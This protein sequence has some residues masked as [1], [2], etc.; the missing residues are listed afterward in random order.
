MIYKDFIKMIQPLFVI[1]Y[2]LYYSFIYHTHLS[3]KLK[4]SMVPDEISLTFLF[5]C[6]QRKLISLSA[7]LRQQCPLTGMN[8]SLPWWIFREEQVTFRSLKG[9]FSSPPHQPCN[10]GLKH[11]F[12]YISLLLY[13]QK[14]QLTQSANL[15]IFKTVNFP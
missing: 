8:H 6:I 2:F 3:K 9:I 5:P 12:W 4:H 11:G 1:I 13:N 7:S 10:L 14:L 15:D